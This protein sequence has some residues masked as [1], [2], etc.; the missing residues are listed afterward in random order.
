[1]EYKVEVKME[2]AETFK[3]VSKCEELGLEKEKQVVGLT[4]LALYLESN[5]ITVNDYKNKGLDLEM[6]VTMCDKTKQTI[7]S[8]YG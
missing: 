3:V 6:S 4:D 8:Y 7:D 2:K 5:V 1:M